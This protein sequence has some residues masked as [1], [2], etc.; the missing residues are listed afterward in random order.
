MEPCEV[1]EEGSDSSFASSPAL[2]LLLLG[3]SIK[4]C[5]SSPACCECPYDALIGHIREEAP[6]FLH[7][8]GALVHSA[9]SSLRNSAPNLRPQACELL[10]N[11][12][13]AGIRSASI[14]ARFFHSR[15][16]LT[17]EDWATFHVAR[18]SGDHQTNSALGTSNRPS[19]RLLVID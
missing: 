19:Q 3:S 16:S 1:D 2:L 11:G 9:T 18:H 14:A 17:D 13:L 5:S 8:P 12:I 6:K 10:R 15:R 7:P 4:E